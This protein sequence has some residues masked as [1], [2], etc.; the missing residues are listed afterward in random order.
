MYQFMYIR[1]VHLYFHLFFFF[2]NLILVLWCI[3]VCSKNNETFK[4]LA[5]WFS[6]L[7]TFILSFHNSSIW[8]EFTETPFISLNL[9][10]LVLDFREQIS[11]YFYINMK[12]YQAHWFQMISYDVCD[13]IR[14][15]F[16][17]MYEVMH[18]NQRF[19]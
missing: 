17:L 11:F 2:F 10:F 15:Y 7:R 14:I 8:T 19:L 5:G 18:Y 6:L 16:K 13:K 9:K 1:H 4:S 12:N 3:H